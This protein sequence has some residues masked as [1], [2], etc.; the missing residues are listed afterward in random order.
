LMRQV[1]SPHGLQTAL[2]RD[3]LLNVAYQKLRALRG[4][5]RNSQPPADGLGDF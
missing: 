5:L 4:D 2:A 1:E 3:P